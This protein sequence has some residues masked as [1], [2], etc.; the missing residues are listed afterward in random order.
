MDTHLGQNHSYASLDEQRLRCFEEA[1][2]RPVRSEVMAAIVMVING[3]RDGQLV[4]RSVLRS[5]VEVFVAMG[6]NPDKTKDLALYRRE[7]EAPLLAASE[8]YFAQSAA[9]WLEGS[10]PAY[11]EHVENL[12]GSEADRVRKCMDISTEGPL[13]RLIEDVMLRRQLGRLVENEGSG[14]RV[15]LRE[16]KREDLARLFRLYSRLRVDQGLMKLAEVFKDHLLELGSSLVRDRLVR[17]GSAIAGGAG[18][19][20]GPGAGAGAGTRAGAGAGAGA[21][22]SE[23]RRVGEE[24]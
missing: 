21:G 4:D 10:V 8:E 17:A 24:C 12:L 16:E 5:C 23:E 18:A 14:V 6:Q 22:R 1:C 19:G 15:L 2:F 3:E 9:R 20:A 7:L 13:L 11:L